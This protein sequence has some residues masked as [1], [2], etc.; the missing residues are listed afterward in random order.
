MNS[1]KIPF[2]YTWGSKLTEFNNLNG[3][4]II[5][6]HPPSKLLLLIVEEGLKFKR[7]SFGRGKAVAYAESVNMNAYKAIK[8]DKLKPYE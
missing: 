1:E 4:G 8:C 6:L 3:Y 7:V 2:G 5:K